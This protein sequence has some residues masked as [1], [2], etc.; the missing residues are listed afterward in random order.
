MAA[1]PRIPTSNPA[2]RRAPWRSRS[3]VRVVTTAPTRGTAAIKR[4]VRE[5]VS[6]VSACESRSHGTAISMMVKASSGRTRRAR[7]RNSSRITAI[8]TSSTAAIPVRAKTSVT[9][10]SSRTATRIRRYGMPQITHIAAKSSQPRRVIASLLSVA[11]GQ[12]TPSLAPT[13]STT[14][15]GI[16]AC[17]ESRRHMRTISAQSLG[18]IMSSPARPDQ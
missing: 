8:G 15:C 10:V 16:R 12:P 13:R 7:G 17:G 5:L 3:P 11:R 14:T 2:Q 4:P 9:G 18:W 1:T 6:R